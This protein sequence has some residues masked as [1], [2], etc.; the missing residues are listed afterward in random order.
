MKNNR[1]LYDFIVY[2][3]LIEFFII[4][5]YNPVYVNHILIL[6][7]WLVAIHFVCWYCEV[8]TH[9]RVYSDRVNIGFGIY[10]WKSSAVFMCICMHGWLY[11]CICMCMVVYLCVWCVFNMC[12]YLFLCICIYECVCL[13]VGRWVGVLLYVCVCVMCVSIAFLYYRLTTSS[14]LDLLT[15][16]SLEVSKILNFLYYILIYLVLMCE[17]SPA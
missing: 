2:I 15:S 12:I 4:I 7:E 11:M 9:I 3:W 17:A 6:E 16:L 1:N 5:L 10:V 13:L 8:A 14:A